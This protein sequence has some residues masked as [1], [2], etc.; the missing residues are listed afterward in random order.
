M[1]CIFAFP[2]TWNYLMNIHK[3]NQTEQKLFIPTTDWIP[4]CFPTEWG[5][6][7]SY[8]HV[9][10]L[11]WQ[12]N[13]NQPTTVKALLT[14]SAH[15][16]D[17]LWPKGHA[18]EMTSLLEENVLSWKRWNG[19]YVDNL[20]VAHR[21]R[22]HGAFWYPKWRLMFKWNAEIDSQFASFS[23]RVTQIVLMFQGRKQN[24]IGR[25]RLDLGNVHLLLLLL[26][27]SFHSVAVVLTLVQTKQIIY[28]NE[29]I[30]KHSTNNTKNS[31]NNTKT[32]YKQYKN[33]VQIIQ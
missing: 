24:W 30:Q 12:W 6:L 29:I 17:L 23:N 18:T 15:D 25:Q 8:L 27:F 22:K 3:I 1:Y 7:P 2:F 9:V 13:K 20:T 4:T 10:K 5:L 19:K 16:K 26:Q 33:T 14:P 11:I 32:R 31:T 28:I 21:I